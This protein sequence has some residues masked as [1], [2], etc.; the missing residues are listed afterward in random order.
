VK[1]A[2]SPPRRRRQQRVQVHLVEPQ[3]FGQRRSDR[4]AH[5][6]GR[7]PPPPAP[8]PTLGR[9]RH[10]TN[11]TGSTRRQRT[12][13]KAFQ[14][15]FHFR[16]AAARRSRAQMGEQEGGRDANG[17]DPRSGAMVSGPDPPVIGRATAAQC[18]RSFTARWKSRANTP[19]ARPQAPATHKT[20][21]L[22]I[23][24][25]SL[26]LHTQAHP[27]LTRSKLVA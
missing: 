14:C 11:L 21:A 4:G 15:A 18:I 27:R 17:R 7:A 26:D 23:D 19:V 24:G 3:P 20:R 1:A 9:A 16:H 10:P 22:E 12:S 2:A 8:G 25:A 5:V 6:D 13:R